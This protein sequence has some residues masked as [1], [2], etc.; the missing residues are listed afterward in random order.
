MMV[1]GLKDLWFCFLDTVYHQ[2]LVDIDIIQVF[3][4]AWQ[5]GRRFSRGRSP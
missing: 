5:R 2:R 3:E 1:P 4:L